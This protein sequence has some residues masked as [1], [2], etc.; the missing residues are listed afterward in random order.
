[1]HSCGLCDT[2]SHY[3][4]VWPP[5]QARFAALEPGISVLV[6]VRGHS[7]HQAHMAIMHPFLCRQIMQAIDCSI[8]PASL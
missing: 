1:M 3:A 4:G 6:S 2:S 5:V 8:S 7:M